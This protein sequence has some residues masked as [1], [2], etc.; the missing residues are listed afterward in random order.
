MTAPAPGIF[1]PL[2]ITTLLVSLLA[3]LASGTNY[4]GFSSMGVSS[5]T[6]GSRVTTA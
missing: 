1:S 5:Q 6:N 3:A 4:V 2:R